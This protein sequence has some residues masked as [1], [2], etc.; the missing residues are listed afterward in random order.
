VEEERLNKFGSWLGNVEGVTK[1]YYLIILT[2]SCKKNKFQYVKKCDVK[3]PFTRM[4]PFE[5]MWV[6]SHYEGFKKI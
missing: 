3:R 6:P 5:N 1:K 2:Y 4:T